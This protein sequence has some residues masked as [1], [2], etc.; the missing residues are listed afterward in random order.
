MQDNI[1]IISK[2]PKESPEG[3]SFFM[4]IYT[5]FTLTVLVAVQDPNALLEPFVTI[6]RT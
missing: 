3:L 1:F 6:A 5:Y 4:L 2:T